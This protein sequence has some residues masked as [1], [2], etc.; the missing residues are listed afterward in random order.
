MLLHS[1][2]VMAF[3]SQFG[4]LVFLMT[5]RMLFAL[6]SFEFYKEEDVATV[7]LVMGAAGPG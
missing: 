2:V 4:V 7:D 5:M 3:G 6:M 1:V